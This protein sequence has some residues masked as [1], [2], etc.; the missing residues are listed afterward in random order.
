MAE[1]ISPAALI[2]AM[3]RL[4]PEA[5]EHIALLAD[6]VYHGRISGPHAFADRV[7]EI[8]GGTIL[9]DAL[10][11]VKGAPMVSSA[12]DGDFGL[13]GE[14]FR[15]CV[16]CNGGC[17][18]PGCAEM[19]SFCQALHAHAQSCEQPESCRTC[20]RWTHILCAARQSVPG[21]LAG[22]APTRTNK[23]LVTA[24]PAPPP[25]RKPA[26]APK[27]AMPA[28]L[29]MLAR[30]ALGELSSPSSPRGSPRN[31]PRNSP[32]PSPDWQRPKRQKALDGGSGTS[33][34]SHSPLCTPGFVR[35]A[36]AGTSHLAHVENN[37]Q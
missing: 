29:M 17:R 22:S 27:P 30:S 1:Q 20:V 31:S 8:F 26:D 13:R 34:R 14:L 32:C 7:R 4:K 36:G 2:N 19:R 35:R 18:L 15:H 16:K 6:E 25:T 28:H 24:I 11:L 9:L 3:A 23:V 5:S 10:L 37:R 21:A 33:V 12:S